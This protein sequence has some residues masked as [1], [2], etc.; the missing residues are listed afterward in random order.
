MEQQVVGSL[1]GLDLV[2]ELI[3]NGITRIISVMTLV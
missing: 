2:Y 3:F 1:F